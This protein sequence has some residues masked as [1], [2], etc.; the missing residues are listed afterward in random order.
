VTMFRAITD[1]ILESLYAFSIE[2]YASPVILS[3]ILLGITTVA[4]AAFSKSSW[5]MRPLSAVSVATGEFKA[6]APPENTNKDAA[7]GNANKD[8]TWGGT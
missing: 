4:L 7:D 6:P 2:P 8:R 3:L 5:H 1:D